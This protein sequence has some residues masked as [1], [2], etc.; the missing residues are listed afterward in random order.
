[1]D[2]LAQLEPARELLNGFVVQ[3]DV[4]PPLAR[5]ELRASRDVAGARASIAVEL[6]ACVRR[7]SAVGGAW[8]NCRQRS[9]RNYQSCRAEPGRRVAGDGDRIWRRMP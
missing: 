5:P 1:M 8:L 4:R 9:Y 6:V 7:A 3:L 2:D